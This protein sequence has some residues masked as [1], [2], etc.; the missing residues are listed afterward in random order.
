MDGNST[1]GQNCQGQCQVN[2]FY[3]SVVAQPKV[4]Y[5]E[6]YKFSSGRERKIWGKLP[7]P[8]RIG[9]RFGRLLRLVVI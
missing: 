6:V 4:S 7:L 5:D 3:L 8:R 2:L 9:W 1:G